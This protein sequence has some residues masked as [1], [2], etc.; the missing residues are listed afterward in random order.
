MAAAV[1]TANN[2]G[3]GLFSGVYGSVSASGDW[4]QMPVRGSDFASVSIQLSGTFSGTITWEVSHDGTNWIASAYATRTDTAS[5]NRTVAAS[6]AGTTATTWELPLCGQTTHVRARCT[7]YT[8]GTFVLTLAPCKPYVP[9][10]PVT[11]TLF[12]VSTSAGANNNTGT[13][14][15]GGWSSAAIMLV[16]TTATTGPIT[17]AIV[18][19]A[20]VATTIGTA[21]TLV[22]GSYAFLPSLGT[23]AILNATITSQSIP[24]L[25]LPKRWSLSTTGASTSAQRILVTVRR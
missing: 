6:V 25:P 21:T 20:G 14:E 13:L 15:L 9:G 7:A 18:D 5:A 17:Q 10:V 1:A 4:V 11:A 2:G 3:L 23:A 16:V 19:D 22:A 12:D 8:S 24:P